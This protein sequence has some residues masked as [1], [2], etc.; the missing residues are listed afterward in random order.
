MKFFAAAGL[1]LGVLAL[2]Y[3]C[4]I[5]GVLGVIFGLFW[6]KVKKEAAFPFGP[7][8]IMAFYILFLMNSSLLL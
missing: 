2:P 8:L 1:W 6:Q 5:A 3:F 4:M 7:S